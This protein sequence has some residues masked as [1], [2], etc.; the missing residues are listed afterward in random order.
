MQVPAFGALYAT[1][2]DAPNPDDVAGW[3]VQFYAFDE[4]VQRHAGYAH[5]HTQLSDDLPAATVLQSVAAGAGGAILGG[6]DFLQSSIEGTVILARNTFAAAGYRTGILGEGARAYDQEFSQLVNT[7]TSWNGLKSAGSRWVE[8]M[9][10]DHHRANELMASGDAMGLMLGT[11]IRTRQT[12]E[13]A[14]VA[15]GG[16]GATSR[17]G[18]RTDGT[19]GPI[20]LRAVMESGPALRTRDLPAHMSSL[21]PRRK[22]LCV[23]DLCGSLRSRYEALITHFRSGVR[24]MDSRRR[25]PKVCV[26]IVSLS[27]CCSA[28]RRAEFSA[29]RCR[30]LA[31]RFWQYW[32][33]GKGRYGNCLGFY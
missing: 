21:T 32:S 30:A 8:G 28:V 16:Y 3:R 5:G 31:W 33:G 12:L 27:P 11:R 7:V 14:S 24:R 4:Q 13:V 18:E 25:R 15:T 20:S 22:A 10:A 6:A 9:V 29:R 2:L 23:Q 1:G 19:F 17:R 26:L